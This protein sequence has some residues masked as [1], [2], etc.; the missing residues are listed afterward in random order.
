MIFFFIFSVIFDHVQWNWPSQS[1]LNA[2]PREQHVPS[3]YLKPLTFTWFS[4]FSYHRIPYFASHQLIA[5]CPRH[6]IFFVNV[7]LEIIYFPRFSLRTIL[8]PLT[9][10]CEFN[11]YDLMEYGHTQCELWRCVHV[12]MDMRL[13]TKTWIR[14]LHWKLFNFFCVFSVIICF[15]LWKDRRRQREEQNDELK[16]GKC[17]TVV[18]VWIFN[19]LYSFLS[20]ALLI[21][22]IVC[23]LLWLSS[24]SGIYSH[25][26]EWIGRDNLSKITWKTLW[27][28][29]TVFFY[30][31]KLILSCLKY[32]WVVFY[33][34]MRAHSYVWAM[35]LD[36]CIA[37]VYVVIKNSNSRMWAFVLDAWLCWTAA[38][39]SP[40]GRNEKKNEQFHR[41]K[42][43]TFTTINHFHEYKFWLENLKFLWIFGFRFS[44]LA[45][46]KRFCINERRRKENRKF[47]NIHSRHDVSRISAASDFL[48]WES[49][50]Y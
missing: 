44:S 16:Q 6:I 48:I 8:L 32:M 7:N 29:R 10:P 5:H 15:G 31:L 33:Y 24:S 9:I 3:T 14:A 46:L 49:I 23:C 39:V 50:F 1:Y 12:I 30:T 21:A 2:Q 4:S 43:K 34:T 17:C 19:A 38:G 45:P 40:V 28:S 22:D 20:L 27:H 25:Q 47:F 35:F 42:K 11:L 36:M 41:T 13:S 26:S 37:A 18:F